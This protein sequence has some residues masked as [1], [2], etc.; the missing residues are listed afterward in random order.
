MS[1]INFSARSSLPIIR[2]AIIAA[3]AAIFASCSMHFRKGP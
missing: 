2:A 1:A 3:L